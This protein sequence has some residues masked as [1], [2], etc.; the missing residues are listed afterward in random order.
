MMNGTVR[1]KLV[2]NYQNTHIA[3]A[4]Q[5]T[6]AKMNVFRIAALATR[7]SLSI[8]AIIQSCTGIRATN[9]FLIVGRVL[10]Q[11]VKPSILVVNRGQSNQIV[12]GPN[13][14]GYNPEEGEFRIALPDEYQGGYMSQVLAN[15]MFEIFVT[16]LED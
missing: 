15:S 2:Q 8:E 5:Q 1:M 4:M 14:M 3:F 10:D 16:S 9:G 13:R 6:G 7:K 12:V 11:M